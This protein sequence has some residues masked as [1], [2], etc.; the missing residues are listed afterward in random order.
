MQQVVF[1]SKVKRN[2]YV[3][4][5]CRAVNDAGMGVQAVVYDHFSSSWLWRNRHRV[6]VLH[7]HWLELFF[8]YPSLL[9]SIKRWLSVMLGLILGRA[10]GV[11]IVYTMHNI[12]QHESKRPGLVWLGNRLLLKL[13]QAI[14]V[15]D[16]QTATFL[17][18]KWGRTAGVH[19]VPHG[20]YVGAYANNIS[21]SQAR[22]QLELP[23]D[24]FVFLSLGRVRPY[25]GLDDLLLAFR[26][27]DDAGAVLLI[28]GEPQ[29][30]AF[31]DQV[32]AMVGGDA[33]VRLRL[34]YVEED[35]LQL[36]FNASDICVLPYRHV[37][38]SGAAIL[39]FSFGTPIIAPSLGCFVELVDHGRR[40]ILYPPGDV[41]GL[42]GALA[43]ARAADLGRMRSAVWEHVEALDWG[44]LAHRHI[45][46]YR[47][48]NPDS[49]RRAA[50]S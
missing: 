47:A 36:F 42:R 19:V 4:L 30:P 43:S 50:G 13:A 17:G 15:H 29:E 37:T 31:A 44:T 41:S 16:E 1:L 7:I 10:I 20:N 12:W 34:S 5:L 33:R 6:D 18:K 28:A 38:T 48:A 26:A 35:A 39:A 45:A 2:P 23:P 46:M 32:K 8:V 49:D 25:K 21:R 9:R 22:Q 24:A 40:G 3:S 14:H 27:F 11:R